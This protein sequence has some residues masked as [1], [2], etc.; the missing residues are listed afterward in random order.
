MFDPLHAF[1]RWL[2]DFAGRH[3]H[4]IA[5]LE[6]VSTTAAII[7]ALY[8]SYAARRTNLPRLVALAAISIIYADGRPPA[9]APRYVTV[10]L[11]NVGNVPI[12]LNSNFF[13]WQLRFNRKTAWLAIPVDEAGDNHEPVRQY[14][15][16]LM[17]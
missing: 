1:M 2:E 11:T 15:F 8:V 14:P 6:A 3:S 12:R 17:P 10:R 9:T 4:T 5:L 7:V 16:V 13:S